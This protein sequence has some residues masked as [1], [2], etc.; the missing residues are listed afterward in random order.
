TYSE[1]RECVDAQR[2]DGRIAVETERAIG[3]SVADQADGEREN[4]GS[5]DHPFVPVSALSFFSPHGL[6]ARYPRR[7]SQIRS[8]CA[9]GR[10][11]AAP[12]RRS[13]ARHLPCT[14]RNRG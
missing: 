10:R 13:A 5:L 8:P 4:A 6:D 3:A 1:E 2:V 11:Y 12:A 7:Q 14:A 9:R